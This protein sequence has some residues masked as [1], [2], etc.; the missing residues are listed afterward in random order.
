MY[1]DYIIVFFCSLSQALCNE[2]C[3][4]ITDNLSRCTLLAERPYLS[5]LVNILSHQ[6]SVFY[7]C[8]RVS[9]LRLALIAFINK[10][11][12]YSY[13]LLW[14][15]WQFVK[16]HHFRC[17]T[18]AISCSLSAFEMILCNASQNATNTFRIFACLVYT[19][20]FN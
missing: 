1:G 13:F 11:S 3:A 8:E 5:R 14:Q 18:L 17:S 2:L 10:V 6:D 16:S 9:S 4:K 19:T 12:R 20:D 15:V 7:L